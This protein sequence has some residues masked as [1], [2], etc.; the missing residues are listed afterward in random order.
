MASTMPR[1]SSSSSAASSFWMRS[2]TA[3]P[4]ES[5]WKRTSTK[6]PRPGAPMNTVCSFTPTVR[7][8]IV[9]AV[10]PTW[11]TVPLNSW[12]SPGSL[13]R[14]DTTCAERPRLLMTRTSEACGRRPAS[15]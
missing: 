7:P 5:R 1:N 10:S 15:A 6:S 13:P 12:S 11:T 2:A 8:S 4:C 3:L 14:P 9:H